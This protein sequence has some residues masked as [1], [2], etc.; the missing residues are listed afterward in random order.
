MHIGHNH[1]DIDKQ[2]LAIRHLGAGIIKERN[3]LYE[4]ALAEYQ[5]AVEMD[6][7]LQVAWVKIQDLEKRLG[8]SKTISN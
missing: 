8:N 1:E 3:A 4:A 7:E 5:A 6:P 2:D